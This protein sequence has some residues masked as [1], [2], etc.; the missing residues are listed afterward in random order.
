M[1]GGEISVM[2]TLR[3]SRWLRVLSLAGLLVQIVIAAAHF[4][5]DTPRGPVNAVIAALA[6]SGDTMATADADVSEPYDAPFDHSGDR[7]HCLLCWS[8][9]VAASA[10]LTTP[11]DAAL[12]QVVFKEDAGALNLAPERLDVASAFDARG[13]PAP[14]LT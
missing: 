7:D 4:H 5:N 3:A 9:G 6:L 11:I 13:P 10:L 8:A 14:R 1:Q 2:P 12:P